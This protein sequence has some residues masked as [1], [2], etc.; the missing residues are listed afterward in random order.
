[1]HLTI[2]TTSHFI[3]HPYAVDFATSRAARP[4]P[5]NEDDPQ[6]RP[7]DSYAEAASV[8]LRIKRG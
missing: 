2:A 4:H 8:P 7:L 5:S 3:H 6:T 1:M